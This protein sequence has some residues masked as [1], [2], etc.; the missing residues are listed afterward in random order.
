TFATFSLKA[1][2]ALF[3]FENAPL[4]A[5]LPISVTA[6]GITAQFSATGQGFSIQPANT[7]GFT[8]AGFSGNC[9]YPNSVY[10][11]DLLASFSTPLVRFSILYAPQELGCDS[12]ATLRVTAF[13]DGVVVGTSTTNASSPGTWPSEILAFSSAQSFNS[14]VSHY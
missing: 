7:M 13:M 14:V 11:A 9:I 3:D 6:G 12:S 5:S 2:D 4:H 8:P 1:E 10:A